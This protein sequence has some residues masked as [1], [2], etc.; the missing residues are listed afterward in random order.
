MASPVYQP[1]WDTVQN[2]L[3]ACYWGVLGVFGSVVA[4]HVVAITALFVAAVAI[5]GFA[6]QAMA[7]NVGADTDAAL[8]WGIIAL[9]TP[10]GLLLA[11]FQISQNAEELQPYAMGYVA[12]AVVSALLMVTAPPAAVLLLLLC[13]IGIIAA[14]FSFLFGVIRCLW[15]PVESGARLFLWLCL[16]STVAAVAT[17]VVATNFA[18]LANTV[19][20]TL[21]SG[22]VKGAAVLILALG[23]ISHLLF[24]WFLRTIARHFQSRVTMAFISE[25][26]GVAILINL[27]GLATGA[28]VGSLP[29]DPLIV[30]AGLVIQTW[31]AGFVGLRLLSVVAAA[32]DV[33]RW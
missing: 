11:L 26:F 5:T 14:S 22:W 24:V 6:T 13:G 27:V 4:L 1:A 30:F 23:T 8:P 3:N 10:I 12:L 7:A 29:G 16:A 18:E 2:G 15:V 25:Y 32:R 20:A 9:S 17:P 33:I 31:I 19:P 21:K 28:V